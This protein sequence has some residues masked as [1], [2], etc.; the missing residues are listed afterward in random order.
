ME[1]YKQRFII[2]NLDVLTTAERK[3]FS[4]LSFQ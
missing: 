4:K 3:Q 1:L 2:A